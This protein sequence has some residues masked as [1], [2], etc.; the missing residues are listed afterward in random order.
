MFNHDHSNT[1]ITITT[2]T[3]IVISIDISNQQLPKTLSSVHTVCTYMCM[4]VCLC[5]HVYICV[6]IHIYRVHEAR[7]LKMRS[8]VTVVCSNYSCPFSFS[9][10]FNT[11]SFWN[12]IQENASSAI[13][14]LFLQILCTTHLSFFLCSRDLVT[15]FV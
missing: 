1:A 3:V 7:M 8:F 9:L 10:S 12:V 5:V 11:L 14:P 2:A 13:N 4:C 6:R 15:D